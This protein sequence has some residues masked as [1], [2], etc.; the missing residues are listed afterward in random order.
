MDEIEF[1][2]SQLPGQNY[3][4]FSLNPTL[5]R[6]FVRSQLQCLLDQ[7]DQGQ[8]GHGGDA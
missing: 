6:A 4:S 8:Q 2:L 5:K 7:T 1:V 3:A